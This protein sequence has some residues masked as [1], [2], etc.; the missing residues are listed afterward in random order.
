LRTGAAF[1][2]GDLLRSF[3]DFVPSASDEVRKLQ[4]SERDR[5][6]AALE[7]QRAA[8]EVVPTEGKPAEIRRALERIHDELIRLEAAF[9]RLPSLGLVTDR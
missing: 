3:E 8:L 1:R 2:L 6:A 9:E 7:Q 4:L 5:L